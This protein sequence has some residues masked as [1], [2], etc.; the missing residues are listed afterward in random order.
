MPQTDPV[1]NPSPSEAAGSNVRVEDYASGR[2]HRFFLRHPRVM[3]TIVVAW[4]GLPAAA[5]L[6]F[7]YIA[8]I[9]SDEKVSQPASLPVYITAWLVTITAL[10][11]RR[12]RP[13]TAVIVSIASGIAV[14][15]TAGTSGGFEFATAFAVYAVATRRDPRQGWMA[16][17][18]ATLMM[19]GSVSL[20][21]AAQADP[22]AVENQA[23]G[24]WP[25]A[26]TTSVF[27]LTLHLIA[28][29]I[30]SSVYAR[31][32]R[33]GSLV[34]RAWQLERDRDQREQLAIVDE[35]ARIARELHDV[36]AH[37]LTVMV[38]LSEGAAR[39]AASHPARASEV[40]R[41][42]ASA[43]R[44]ALRDTRH[45]VGVLR[46]EEE[47]DGVPLA[48]APTTGLHELIAQFRSAGLDVELRREGELP[49]D[50]ALRLTVYRVVQ[51]SLTNVLRYAPLSPRIEAVIRNSDEGVTVLIDNAP[52]PGTSV[53]PM[54]SG[55]GIVGMRERVAT[56]GGTLTAGR[57]ATGWRVHAFLP[58]PG[59]EPA[60]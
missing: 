34:E 29:A 38:T 23:Y 21:L 44:D 50:S 54:G 55:R 17:A 12:Q 13:W 6:V 24:V 43:G 40:M 45:V 35:R 48:P 1:S 2:I 22:N 4:F 47:I 59:T 32:E 10:W 58:H 41:S 42:V 30:G 7:S 14:A 57:T 20:I 53:A 49:G 37:S 16:F 26:I 56:L 28:M 8:P 18:A 11:F 52:G 46:S 3:D 39:I 15:A 27:T 5:T 36:V 31:R 25:I 33:I 51:E 19:G 60:E 9:D